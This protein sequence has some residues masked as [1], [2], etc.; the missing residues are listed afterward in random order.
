MS[1]MLPDELWETV[2]RSLPIACVDI[3]LLNRSG[4]IGL[5]RR[6]TPDE[7]EKWCLIGGRARRGETLA[8]GIEREIKDALG[9]RFRVTD[10]SALPITVAEYFPDAPVGKPRDLR[11]HAIGLTYAATGAG[12]ISVTGPEA[13]AFQWLRPDELMEED[14]GFG[15]YGVIMDVLGS[16]WADSVAESG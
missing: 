7:G 12:P 5:I 4:D 10:V 6:R 13:L 8:A 14:V 16:A 2:Q 15:Q 1:A 11:K 9:D 3:L